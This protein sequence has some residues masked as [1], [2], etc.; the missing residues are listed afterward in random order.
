LDEIVPKIRYLGAQRMGI[1]PDDIN[2]TLVAHH[3]IEAWVFSA[4]KGDPPPYYLRVE[5]QGEDIS[6]SIGGEKLLFA[7][8]PLAG[9]PAWHFL[10]AGSA[11][12]LI[13]ALL[14][15]RESHL[16][17]PGPGGL[18]G[19]Y[20]VVVSNAG[21]RLDLPSDLS[22]EDAIGIN[23][24]SH[25]Y[26]GIERIDSDGT[27]VF[28]QETANALQEL[29]GVGEERVKSEEMEGYASEL[30]GRFRK[31]AIKHGVNTQILPQ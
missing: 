31:F 17:V 18:P 26:D 29:L 5:Y 16:H 1:D 14:S 9:G 30:I 21:I 22:L 12:R 19:G 15:D 11:V 23:S 10:S 24:R 4:E 27:V 13:K 20:P 8:Y 28:S 7:P 2:V 6:E 25:R 3:A